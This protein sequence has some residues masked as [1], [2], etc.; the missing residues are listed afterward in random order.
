MND[1]SMGTCVKSLFV[2]SYLMDA[3]VGYPLRKKPNRDA[4][5]HVI[6]VLSGKKSLGRQA[7]T[8]RSLNR[9]VVI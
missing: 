7:R 8:N 5:P 4:R 9:A 3:V 1:R 2:F 6:L